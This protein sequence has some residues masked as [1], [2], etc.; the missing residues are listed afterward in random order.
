MN[1]NKKLSVLISTFTF[2]N[3][4]GSEMY[5]FELAKKLKELNCD[6]TVLSNIG[7]PMISMSNKVGIKTVSLNNMEP[8]KDVEFDIIHTQHFPISQFVCNIY[9][10]IPKLSVIHSEVIHLENPYIHPSIKKYIAIRPEIQNHITKNFN[11]DVSKTEVVYNPVDSKKF[12]TIDTKDD[13]YILF[14]G[15]IDPLRKNTIFDLVGYSKSVNKELWLVGVNH[16]NYLE[17][18]LSNPHVK[19][20]NATIDVEKYVKNCSETAGILLGRTTIEGWMCGKSGWIYQI[21]S[22]G[23]ILSKS[24][25]EVPSDIDKFDSEKVALKIK[26]EYLKILN[27]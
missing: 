22:N 27:S 7:E 25:N 20:F 8:L 16:T 26:E 14:V 3:L 9:P 23:T 2:T 5:T 19:H 21:D 13:G 6:I 10:N 17:Q 18:L 1:K 12:N 24:R 4:T 11:I 15:T